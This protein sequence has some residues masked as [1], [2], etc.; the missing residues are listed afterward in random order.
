MC[1]QIGP[2]GPG[3]APCLAAITIKSSW[4]KVEG[5]TVTGAIGEG[6]LATGSLQGGSISNVEIR[7]NTVTGNDTGAAQS[8]NSP[9][10]QCNPVGPVPGDCGEGIHLMGAFDSIVSHNRVTGNSG[11]VLLTDEF[12]PTHDNVVSD[13]LIKGNLTDCGVTVPG[14]NPS[15]LDANGNPQPDVAGVYDNVIDGNVITGNGV[16]GEGAG[17]LF[18]NATAGTASYDNL[19]IHNF[20]AGNGMAG[21][22]MH[23]HPIAQGTFEDL[24]GNRIIANVIGTNNI[25]GDADANVIGDTVGILVLGDVPVK[26]KIAHNRIFKNDYGIWLGVD[27]NVTAKLRQNRFFDVNI[28]VFSQS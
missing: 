18:A 19:A 6:I 1:D 25:N 14:H 11:G 2:S 9:Y 15:A 20:I 3:S 17:V 5:F 21:V 24:N 8:P 16:I 13:N 28:P 4:V 22:T 26:V 10:P 27:N 23:A 7:D 12:G